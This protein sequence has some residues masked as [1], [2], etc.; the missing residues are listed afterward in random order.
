MGSLGDPDH[1]EREQH[2]SPDVEYADLALPSSYIT[3]SLIAANCLHPPQV[4]AILRRAACE[5]ALRVIR[6][7]LGARSLALRYKRKNI[8]GEVRTTRAEQLL[9]DLRDKVDRARRRYDRSRDALLRLDL[10]ALDHTTYQALGANDLK[11]LSDYL[12]T[13]SAGLG[14]GS[15]AVPW[16]WRVGTPAD[17]EN[18]Q[19]DALKVE[20]FRARQ[21]ATQWEEELKFLKREM[22]MTLNSFRHNQ[23]LWEVKSQQDN[24]PMGMSEYAA[25][26]SQFFKRLADDAFSRGDKMVLDTVVQLDW[27]A[28]QWPTCQ[29]PVGTQ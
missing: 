1:P 19:I 26:K 11:M 22:V 12:D 2:T 17:T 29:A 14:Q 24:L 25:R 23:R 16:I 9:R 10:L 28:K 21:R 13:D 27:A 3:A 5:D 7:L 8:V 4:E 15:Q 6:Y 20:W 18:W